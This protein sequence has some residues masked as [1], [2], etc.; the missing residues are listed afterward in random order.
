MN[1][2]E[3]FPQCRHHLPINALPSH[4]SSC[5]TIIIGS[6]NL[7]NSTRQIPNMSQFPRMAFQRLKDIS[8]ASH[9]ALSSSWLTFSMVESWMPEPM[10]WMLW[11]RDVTMATARWGP[12]GANPHTV[13]TLSPPTLIVPQTK[14]INL[15]RRRFALR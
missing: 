1:I 6:C 15:L 7:S 9:R 14:F 3:D 12:D 2:W 5:R 8:K 4:R 11:T 10:L 13:S